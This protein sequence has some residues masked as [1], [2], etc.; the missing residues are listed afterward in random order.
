MKAVRDESQSIGNF[1]MWLREHH[2]TICQFNGA[3]CGSEYMP[4]RK[5]IEE[6]LADYF[7]IDLRR[8]EKEKQA[9]IDLMVAMQNT[10]MGAINVK[11]P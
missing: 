3:R 6:L 2:Y 1:L 9:M 5:T 10:K 11:L 7:D 8:V 4:A